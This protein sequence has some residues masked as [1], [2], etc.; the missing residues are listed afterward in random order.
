[1]DISETF[2]GVVFH[3]FDITGGTEEN[4]TLT[5]RMPLSRLAG[6]GNLPRSPTW[7]P[8]CLPVAALHFLW[9]HNPVSIIFGYPSVLQP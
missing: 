8:G 4:R 9:G 7:S 1:M 3:T 5:S 6:A 2:E